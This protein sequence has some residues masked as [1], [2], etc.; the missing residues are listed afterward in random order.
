MEALVTKGV[1]R[2]NTRKIWNSCETTDILTEIQVISRSVYQLVNLENNGEYN[3]S[4]G[5][6]NETHGYDVRTLELCIA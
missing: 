2:H 4:V 3:S 1:Q 5:L 6:G